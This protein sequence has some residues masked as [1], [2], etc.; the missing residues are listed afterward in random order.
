[1]PAQREHWRSNFG[2]IL[3]AAG[4]AIGLGN[5]WR[6]P[7]T[8]GEHGGG[9]FVLVYL[10]CILIIG[11][12]VM[13]CEMAL[14]RHT[15]RNPVGAF[16]LL[17]PSSCGLA[18]TI[19]SFVMLAGVILLCF[20]NWGWGVLCLALGGV[21]FR[22]RWT[23]VGFMGLLAGFLILSFYS[24]IA[25]WTIH[26]AYLALSGGLHFDSADT[27]QKLFTDFTNNPW[28]MIFY[29]ALF[30]V[31]CALI[32]IKGVRSGIE[33]WARI[34]MPLLFVL[35][36]LL[37]VRG[38]SLEGGRKGIQFYLTPDFSKI[39]AA[40]ILA[41]LGQA[42]FS[43]SL[44]MGAIITYGSYLS[45]KQNLFTSSLSVV[46]LDT[47]IALMAGLIIFPAVYAFG[48]EPTS[49]PGLVFIVLPS[50]F[51]IMPAGAFWAF[52]FFMLIL[53][54]AL[55]SG[56]S[57]LEV[58]IAYFVDERRWPRK[59]ATLVFS[60]VVFLLGTLTAISFNNWDRIGWLQRQLIR[61]FGAAN[62][63]FFSLVSTLTDSWLLPLGGV[64]IALFVGWVWGTTHAVNEIR[65]GS[66]NFADVHVFTL[67]A[68]LKDDP[69]HNERT[70]AFTLASIWGFFIRFISPV[71]VAIA[72]LYTIGWIQ[73]AAPAAPD[74]GDP[75]PP[76]L[77]E[78]A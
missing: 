54:A 17:N 35:M 9:A 75:P 44:G 63:S 61:L 22:Y 51:S 14:G 73:A 57:L 56:I 8:V 59:R 32:V 42:F 1:M 37:I 38:I 76:A 47:L 48:F 60:G 72:F 34:L 33:R 39:T 18:H 5:I 10:A 67:L 25:G 27:A 7:Y 15:Q 13:I 45:K 62:D 6:F 41:A 11:L 28:S 23:V 53:V 43:L 46:G 21:I 40:S 52:L 12:P 74:A 49:G 30:I 3:A 71:A 2:F 68:G 31:L 29:H 26:Y 66:E 78:P 58:I 64:L 20:R 77:E 70:H 69:S 16:S 24:V 4:S 55:T 19:G 65:E 50:V 36:L